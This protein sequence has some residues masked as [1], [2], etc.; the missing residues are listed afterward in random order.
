M[1]KF[2]SKM[3]VLLMPSNKNILR[4]LG[5]VGNIAKFTSPLKL[6]DYLASG[7]LIISSKLKVFEEIIT[8]NKDCIMINN[9]DPH[10]WLKKIKGLNKKVNKI[11]KIKKN[12]YLLSKKYSYDNRAKLILKNL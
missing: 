9:L 11:N 10:K 4:S 1:G 3:D 5:G 2:I 8:N 6:F 12:A 7:K